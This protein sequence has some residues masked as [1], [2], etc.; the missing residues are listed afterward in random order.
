MNR[1][2]EPPGSNGG[3]ESEDFPAPGSSE[4]VPSPEPSA[5]ASWSLLEVLL[6]GLIAIG[7]LTVLS[8]VIAGVVG[9]PNRVLVFSAL[10]TGLA[11]GSATVVWVLALHRRQF[12]ALGLAS[13]RPW[14]ELAYGLVAGVVLYAFV[15]LIVSPLLLFLASLVFG[16]VAPPNQARL[17]FAERPD[18]V[19]ATVAAVGAIVAAPIGEELFFRGLLF[20]SLRRRFRFSVSAALSAAAFGLV[21]VLPLLIP[22]MF[23]VGLV[24][25][26]VFERRG[27][28]IASIA[29]HAA[30]NV[31]GITSLLLVLT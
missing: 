27:S 30:F 2:G 31:I 5:R 20:R 9:D 12:A 29:A 8:A 22:L 26:Y 16:E 10:A 3:Q 6:V 4:P 13:R 11:F 7:I 15:I 21:H 19:E 14:R 24:L 1:A 23:V 18:Q 28:L 17:L 25:A